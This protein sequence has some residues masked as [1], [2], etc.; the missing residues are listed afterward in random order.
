[1]KEDAKKAGY[2]AVIKVFGKSY[3]AEG[4]TAAEAIEGLSVR[5]AKG[6]GILTIQRGAVRKDRVLMPVA[7]LRLFGSS[8]LSRQVAVKNA[9]S[10]FQGI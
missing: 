5:N 6:R 10:L 8:G 1:M 4:G 7:V 9:A 2:K 3:E